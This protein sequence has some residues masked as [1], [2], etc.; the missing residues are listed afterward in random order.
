MPSTFTKTPTMALSGNHLL[1]SPG[2]GGCHPTSR[3]QSH[4]RVPLDAKDAFRSSSSLK[5]ITKS[6]LVVC[7]SECHSRT[8]PLGALVIVC[9]CNIPGVPISLGSQKR[10]CARCMKICPWGNLSNFQQ[11]EGSSENSKSIPPTLL[12]LSK[13]AIFLHTYDVF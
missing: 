11:G 4:A 12:Y 9:W 13:S 10:L 7:W 3:Q 5:S 8:E 6:Q 2:S 1:L